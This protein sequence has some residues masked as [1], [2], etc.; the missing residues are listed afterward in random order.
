MELKYLDFYVN[1]DGS[2]AFVDF[3]DETV[4]QYSNNFIVRVI[5]LGLEADTIKLN[6]LQPDGV[7]LPQK[8]LSYQTYYVEYQNV[9]RPVWE[10]RLSQLDTSVVGGDYGEM[11]FT[12]YITNNN[13]IKVSEPVTV[14]IEVAIDSDVIIGDQSSLTNLSENIN[15]L[16]EE[17]QD[18]YDTLS[19]FEG[20]PGKAATVEVGTTTTGLPGTD[21]NVTNSGTIFDA[22]LNFVIPRG[23]QGIQG[24][25]GDKGDKGDT[26]EQGPIGL[27]P[28][29]TAGD[30][31]TG[32]PGTEVIVN[33]TGT[34]ANPILN[35]TIPQGA[36]GA[37]G[38]MGPDGP[39]GPQGIQG[40]QGQG[41]KIAKYYTSVEDLLNDTEPTGIIVGEF[42]L[43]LGDDNEE[44]YGR[45]Y[46]YTPTGY[47]YVADLSIQGIQ[48]PTGEAGQPIQLRKTATYIEWKYVNEGEEAWRQLVPLSE[49]VGPQGPQGP[50][51]FAATVTIGTVTSVASDQ[52]ATVVN[53]GTSTNAIL[54]FNIPKGEDVSNTIDTLTDVNV[55]NLLND[56]ILIYQNG[57]WVNASLAQLTSDIPV[58]LQD[59]DNVEITNLQ[60]GE[61]LTYNGTKWANARTF[62]TQTEL[63]NGSLDARYYTETELDEGVLDARYFTETELET[64]GVLD[65]RYYTE[66][67][68]DTLLSGKISNS[69]KG[70][71][72]GVAT[73]D[74]T[75][76][77]PSTQLP[78]YVDDVKEYDTI[79]NFPNPGEADKI[80]IAIDTN[81]TYRW[82]GTQ[83]V[84]IA[85][86][87]ALGETEFTAYR[88]DRGKIAYDHSQITDGNPHGTT[89]EDVGAAPL[90]H[91]HVMEDITDLDFPVD[92]V[93]G[94]TGEV[95]ITAS[96]TGYSNTDS[97]L[98]A[99][100]VKNAI[101]ELD[102]KK[103]DVASLSSNIN[104]YP[105][106]AASDIVGYFDMVS[107]L[108]DPRYNTTAVNV[109]TGLL[110]GTDILVASLDADPGLFVGNPGV[111]NV[112]TIGNIRKVAGNS[113]NFAEF[114]F[115]I[116]K[117]TA[118]GVE[119]LLGT[120][121]TTNY[122]NPSTNNYSE[123]SAGALLNN[124]TFTDSDR[125]VIKYFANA[126]GTASGYEFQ[127]GG[128][129]PVRTLLPVPVSVIPT[130]DASGVQVTTTNF[131]A[132]L[133]VNEN[134]VQLALDKL[135]DH[136]HDDR[137]YTELE[138]DGILEG[139]QLAGDY[140]TLVDGKVPAAQLPSYVDDVL[141]F[142]NLAAFPAT[143]ESDKIYIAVDT[144]L[145]YRWSG[146][147]Y[148]VIASSLALGETESTA[149]R[150]DRG[151]IAYDHS[152]I[153][154]GNPHGTTFSDV[155][156]APTI[157]EHNDLYYT[158]TELDAGQ[159]DNRYY[160][161]T[162][163]NNGQLNTIYYT[164]T[165]LNNGQLDNRY[166]TETEL[167]NGQLDSR[168]YTETEV[169]TL[170]T[171]KA[172][173]IHTHGINDI[174][175]FD[176]VNP[177]EGE[178][179]VFDGLQWTN[180]N[181]EDIPTSLAALD[182]TNITNPI[183]NQVLQY[184]GNDWV[185]KSK[186]DIDYIDL[187]LYNGNGPTTQEGRLYFDKKQGT[188]SLGLTNN[189][190]LQVGEE[191]I[192]FGKAVTNEFI[193]KGS[194]V[195][196][197]GSSN[198]D[199]MFTKADTT[200]LFWEEPRY[201]IGIASSN[202]D[203]TANELTDPYA[204]YGYVTWFGR[205]ENVVTG[206]F[207]AGE[208]LYWDPTQSDG[209]LTNIE[210]V[211]PNPKVL[212]AAVLKASTNPEAA[213]GVLLVRPEYGFTLEQ[214]H[215]VN[216]DEV[217]DGQVL[218][219]NENNER[220]ENKL[221]TPSDI[222]AQPEGDYATLVN[223]IIP[224]G[225]IPSLAL[226][227]VSVVETILERDEL[228]VEEGDVAVVTDLNTSFIYDGTNWVEISAPSAVTSVNGQQGVIVLDAEDVGA[229]PSTDIRIANW[230]TA[231]SWGD[232][233]LEEYLTSV[234]ISDINATGTPS[235]E[236]YLRGDG[237]WSII[238]GGSGTSVTV[239]DTAPLN[240]NNGDLWW[241][242][243]N[244]KLKV[245]YDDGDSEQW[246]DATP[247]GEGGGG[248]ITEETDPI[249]TAHPA[250]GITE[251][252][253]D[254][255][256]ATVDK[257]EPLAYQDAGTTLGIRADVA[258]D[259]LI[260]PDIT[261]GSLEYDEE[262][263]LPDP[264]SL[265]STGRISIPSAEAGLLVEFNDEEGNQIG[266]ININEES[267]EN[268][269][270]AFSWGDHATAG[271]Q[272][273]GDYAELVDGKINASQLPAIA[274]TDT[275][276]VEDEDEMLEL[277]AET[278]D[279][280]VRTDVDKTF[281]LKG[282]DPTL[283]GDWQELLTPTA[284]AAGVTSVDM[285]VPT[286]FSINGSPITSTGTLQLGF[287]S[288]YSLPTNASQFNWDAAYSHASLTSGS[289]PHNTTFANILS[290][291]TTINGYGITDA[292]TKLE[293]DNLLE[294]ITGGAFIGATP[295][296]SPSPGD[297][298]W[299]SV[300]GL[301]KVYYFDGDS[302]QWVDATPVGG[303]GGG[304]SELDDLTDVD[305]TTE[306]VNG[307][308]LTYNGTSWIASAPAS[309]PDS[310]IQTFVL[311][312]NISS[313]N[314]TSITYASI[315]VIGGKIYKVEMF[316]R[317][318]SNNTSNGIN[319]DIEVTNGLTIS[320]GTSHNIATNGGVVTIYTGDFAGTSFNSV[321]TA[322]TV[323]LQ[324]VNSTIP[325][326]G[327]GNGLLNF[328]FFRSNSSTGTTTIFGTGTKTNIIVTQL[329]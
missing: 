312:N 168:Y 1:N 297:L 141:E 90:E 21:A 275:F 230:D 216:I 295:P 181:F 247:I 37:T 211:A 197:A 217:E 62:Y 127:F 97:T 18:L 321:A 78:S 148:V 279:I 300:S 288:G 254:N 255:W 244:G 102:F 93:N 87:L 284:A 203:G 293:V 271:Y 101:D 152:Q 161:E 94:L 252:D 207:T 316:I 267:V 319:F 10:Y 145:T 4:V 44:E 198:G 104:L 304:A 186:L 292:Y 156:A 315:P 268:W 157:H 8:F 113:N 142:A 100:T 143:G 238:E 177:V 7:T 195:M 182:D 326:S 189:L 130:P 96:N 169:D 154:T 107:S 239:S 190:S 69:E 82:S 139:Y 170:L 314:N 60:T 202:I 234:N 75:G 57:V 214:L 59:L 56:D 280:A 173:T 147:Q 48:G 61:V 129:S 92:S 30:V 324:T 121:D 158:E 231:Y 71:V 249:F 6:I 146:T 99:E 134:T 119:T 160:T 26:G 213:D 302:S 115:R 85:S 137:Y 276:V 29:F 310:R 73:L 109:P 305:L 266:G 318:N 36:T 135:D 80:Y 270:T 83:Y 179:L 283:L 272:P 25:Q 290:K 263:G 171:G 153:T 126:V 223:G 201:L 258:V 311:E 116:Y 63:D 277:E 162:E 103:A 228:E 184:D 110:S 174:T 246:V 226:T 155:G 70:A 42:A 245:Y 296:A 256:N 131:N 79:T 150:G 84:N 264:D 327:N 236:T 41:F 262:T 303:G 54:D 191:T 199:P 12:F 250:S 159:L 220:W 31:V 67:E 229:L 224:T 88:G 111:I 282:T 172:N 306:P 120:S 163:L 323:Y 219:Y 14:G 76:K 106:T 128:T 74:A 23:E 308:V 24:V 286:G 132:L 233:S 176:I 204:K 77:V 166:F 240:P 20:V 32:Q 273:E 285:T 65:E 28:N 259:L 9:N 299:D 123:F 209:K 243:V 52:P 66:T 43:I 192:L 222:G 17:L 260:T 45:L 22:V 227:D 144:N 108:D 122:I 34:N 58:N 225:Q 232:H 210:P 291:P 91:T 72:N 212:I 294:D 248:G 50:Q 196:Y 301:L 274:I 38:P 5:G 86:S 105:T 188:A 3:H 257:T 325:I 39:Q 206:S 175:D 15:D 180:S 118:E 329:N 251:N 149:Y 112:T 136:L 33:I 269:D 221:L 124:G 183:N 140:A 178:V 187:R 165:E 35:I 68:V 167:T 125:V 309:S 49:L 55:A 138:V 328:K 278:G 164:E 289:N 322:N 95:V 40:I 47:E 98:L 265:V 313:S 89:F 151:K 253:I 208:T 13:V 194:V 287:A 298:W 200:S 16:A 281:I 307:D 261:F 320:G 51:G 317:W 205:I 46:L 193:A 81:L 2:I 53:V 237:S 19:E 218:V 114:F 242:S 117:R 64:D 133:T 241:D 11:E 215:N 185:N 27:T 235:S